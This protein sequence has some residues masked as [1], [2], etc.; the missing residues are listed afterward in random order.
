MTH[1]ACELFHEDQYP[2]TFSPSWVTLTRSHSPSTCDFSVPFAFLAIS[3]STPDFCR[4]CTWTCR[5]LHVHKRWFIFY[6]QGRLL[7]LP[8]K[9]DVGPNLAFRACCSCSDCS[10]I[11]VF[12]FVNARA[13]RGK[14]I[15]Q[16]INSSWMCNFHWPSEVCD[17]LCF[18]SLCCACVHCVHRSHFLAM[19]AIGYNGAKNIVILQQN[20]RYFYIFAIAFTNKCQFLH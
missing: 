7:M 5:L 16:A 12:V 14:R 17:V 10:I 15:F 20:I 8:Q 4:P 1:N 6:V 13:Y 18:T 11:P 19:K 3:L 2:T 9:N